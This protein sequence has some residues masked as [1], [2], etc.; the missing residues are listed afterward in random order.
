MKRL[1]RIAVAVSLALSLLPVF[2][3][4]ASAQCTNDNCALECIGYAIRHKTLNC[5]A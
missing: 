5:P 2:A 4:S 3:S 1:I